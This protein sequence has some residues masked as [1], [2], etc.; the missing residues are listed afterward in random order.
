MGFCQGERWVVWGLEW[1]IG[2]HREHRLVGR[3]DVGW[4]E[5]LDGVGV[6]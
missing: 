4:D 1:G 2:S 5:E 3:E 6:V